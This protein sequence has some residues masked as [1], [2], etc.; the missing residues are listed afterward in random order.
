[1]HT[2]PDPNTEFETLLNYLWQSHGF[3]FTG[4]RR[5]SLMR[6]VDG[7][8][9][10]L[11]VASY[12]EYIDYLKQHPE[13]FFPL[14]NTIEINFTSFF[15][16]VSNWEYIAT[17]IVPQ[18]ISSKPADKPIR[19]WSAGCSSGEEIY[20]LAIVLAEAL[21]E[22]QF[23]SRVQI[24]G[25]DVDKEVL[26]QARQGSYSSS[27][28]VDIQGKL[29]E[30]YFHQDGDRYVF[31]QDL[32]RSIR[33]YHHNLIQDAPMPK[34]DLLVCRNVLIYFNIETQVRVLA[35][36]F[37]SLK[38]SGFLFLGH[39]E[40]LPEEITALFSSVNLQH[41]VYSKLPSSQLPARLFTKA[42]KKRQP[43]VG[44]SLHSGK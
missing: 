26:K 43:G 15:R 30:K 7:M 36:F 17:Q 32:R 5:S 16:D 19:I 20:T 2:P 4:Y 44:N 27:A 24:V 39:T 22:E 12:N 25:T 18:L 31:R 11:P 23:R 42:L 8:M 10:M 35:R 40:M 1:M 28:V 14:F 41:R 13:E 33:F 34:I 29:L 3:D 37:F 9:Q 6:R 38:E 21:G